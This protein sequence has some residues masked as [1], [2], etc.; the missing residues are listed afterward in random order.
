MAAGTLDINIEQGATLR[1][2]LVWKTGAPAVPVDV[3][4]YTARMQIRSQI[5]A[6]DALVDISST[7]TVQGHINVG[8]TDGAVEVVIS[9]SAT[10]TLTGKGVYD[11][12]VVA[13]NGDVTRLVQ[14]KVAVSPNVT[15]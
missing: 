5:T 12:E 13:P 9:A 6:A 11:L 14:G 7:P 1:L 10:A 4:G 2:P 3:T 15:R 8:T